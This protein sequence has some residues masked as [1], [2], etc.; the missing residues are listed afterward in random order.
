MNILADRVLEQW[1][2][3]PGAARLGSALLHFVW[4]GALLTAF[5]WMLLVALRR[6]RPQVRY[7]VSLA[8]L[9]VLAACPVITFAVVEV[10]V[11]APAAVLPPNDPIAIPVAVSRADNP[12]G[13]SS[14]IIPVAPAV[15]VWK[16]RLSQSQDWLQRHRLWV[17]FGWLLGV[18]LLS[19]RLATGFIGAER[20]RRLGVSQIARPVQEIVVRLALRLGIRQPVHVLESA[21]AELPTL[22]GWLRP[23]ILLPVSAVSGLTA[24]QM[25]AILAHELAHIRRH[26][27]LV[28]LLQTV[29]ETILFYHPAVWWLSHN[30]RQE[31][32]HCCDDVAV[33]ICADRVAYARALTAMEEMRASAPRWAVAAHGGS[34]TRRIRRLVD[35]PEPANSGRLALLAVAAVLILVAG[36]TLPLRQTAYAEDAAKGN[37]SPKDTE[38]NESPDKAEVKPPRNPN[39]PWSV[40]GRVTDTEGKPLEGVGVS[41]RTGIGTLRLTGKATTNADGKYEFDFGPGIAMANNDVLLQS[42]WI[43]AHMPG[44]SE[45]DLSRQGNL[46]AAFKLPKDAAELGKRTKNDVILPGNARQI[47]FVMVPAAKVSGTLI[48]KDQ[49]PLA[50]YSI[51]LTGDELSLSSSVVAS[52]KTDEQGRFALPDIP[53]GFKWQ[54]L[55]RPAGHQPSGNAWASGVFHFLADGGESDLFV[56]HDS[57]DFSAKRFELQVL[58][59]GVNWRT[60]LK[61]GAEHQQFN[62][63]T[64]PP[65]IKKLVVF[66][67]RVRLVLDPSEAVGSDDSGALRGGAST[68]AKRVS[69]S[70]MKRTRPDAEGRFTLTFDNPLTQLK[71]GNTRQADLGRFPF[72][73]DNPLTPPDG[74]R[75]ALDPEKHQVVLQINANDGGKRMVKVLEQLSARESG[76]YHVDIQIDPELIDE[77][78]V[79]VTFVTIQPEHDEWVKAFFVEGRGTSY[80][81]IWAADSQ[82]LAQ[83]ALNGQATGW[84]DEVLT[85]TQ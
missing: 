28:N 5:T 15:E 75:W 14:G 79:S 83:V 7:L 34:L 30:I 76:G 57:T 27:Y 72:T 70:N 25:E 1:S 21:V 24:A 31:R 67:T 36:V 41:A 69:K 2:Q 46:L 50:G 62:V 17:V 61:I 47:D 13:N 20:A 56:R 49:Q 78:S 29:V 59:D 11:T 40:F 42:A 10:A 48:D 84:I 54:F 82:Q 19:V 66:A 26:D 71:L 43:S 37:D 53:T 77:S 9:A 6:A 74:G 39:R 81:G 33:A 55:V 64:K 63:T 45:K 80:R 85:P 22:V 58:G 16:D 23:V 68:T 44:F 65:W 52:T 18:C 60:A 35:R 38:S 73:F 32:E 51:A 3:S 4:Q 12:T 8:M